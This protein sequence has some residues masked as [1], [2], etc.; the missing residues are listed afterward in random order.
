VQEVQSAWES[1]KEGDKPAKVVLNKNMGKYVGLSNIQDYMHRPFIYN[2]L[3]LYDWIR[4]STKT[5]RSKVQQAE[6]DKKHE[7]L[8]EYDKEMIDDEIDE[9]DILN[10]EVLDS[11][12]SQ[13]GGE[14]DQNI[15]DSTDYN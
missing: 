9:L 13:L 15:C 11:H 8:N 2:D 10:N 6:F 5:K 3:N 12:V 14:S 4:Q 1:P 7:V